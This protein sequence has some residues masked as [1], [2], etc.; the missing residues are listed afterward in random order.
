MYFGWGKFRDFKKKK[1]E[2]DVEAFK[3][4]GALEFARVAMFGGKNHEALPP[5]KMEK[6][7]SVSK[8][9]IKGIPITQPFR[10]SLT[11]IHWQYHTNEE[12]TEKKTGFL[13][14]YLY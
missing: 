1:R 2:S 3:V 14:T 13:Y 10:N 6:K 4:A 8:L 5:K 12:I 11:F 9:E 7:K